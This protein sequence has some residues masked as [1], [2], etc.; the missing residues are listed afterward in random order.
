MWAEWLKGTWMLDSFIGTDED[1]ASID[2][3]GPGASGFISYSGDGWVSVQIAG[4]GRPRYD[5]PDVAGGTDEQTLA[6]ARG[7]FAYA[8]AFEVDEENGIVYHNLRFS[9]I[10]NW[11]GSRQKRYIEK[12]S[13]D[14]LV[15]TADPARMGPGGKKRKSR[16]RWIRFEG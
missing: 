1:G 6:A 8:G 16:L 14:V 15:L 12:E 13:E 3:M 2:M 10:P 9:L 5:I 11:I 7:L 4:A